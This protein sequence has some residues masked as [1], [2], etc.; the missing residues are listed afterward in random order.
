MGDGLAGWVA[1]NRRSVVNGVPHATFAAAGVTIDTPLQSALV[2]P[3]FFNDQLIGCLS[4]YHADRDRYT[5]DHRRL[6]E[7]VAEQAGPVLHNS[8]TFEQTQEDSLT[9]P[10]TSLPNRRSM[11]MYLTREL[12]RSE[13]LEHQMAVIV[14]DLDRFKS[15][16]D[17]FGHHVGDA[18]LR[19]AAAALTSALRPYDVC[20]RY[21][22]DEF[23][24]ALP[25]CPGDMAEAKR[26]E[27]QER[28]A[29]VQVEVRPGRSIR[30]AASAGLAVY[31][32]DGESYEELLAAA[33]AAMYR[34]KD[35]RR[36]HVRADGPIDASG[37]DTVPPLLV[38]AA[39][40]SAEGAS[41]DR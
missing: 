27:L 20:V 34:D 7:Q 18:A 4:L 38:A 13:R 37:P 19:Q 32:A 36:R 9:D 14:I 29:A 17:T 16:N 25:E 30:L 2:S 35:A 41:L 3:L 6:L 5:D 8:I 39:S 21:A 24:V 31:P 11:F 1:R 22:G 40:P 23:V 26:R 15:I 28:I 10:L 33:D 12:A